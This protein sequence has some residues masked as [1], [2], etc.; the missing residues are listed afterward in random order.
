QI[1]YPGNPEVIDDYFFW[2]GPRR[3]APNAVTVVNTGDLP[4]IGF[5]VQ[6]LLHGPYDARWTKGIF[7]DGVASL[8]LDGASIVT[9]QDVVV[10]VLPARGL[11]TH[12]TFG[13]SRARFDG[14]L[15]LA[16]PHDTLYAIVGLTY[17]DHAVPGLAEV[18]KTFHRSP[19]LPLEPPVV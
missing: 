6:R 14:W 2:R 8:R 4:W 12:G 16:A 11:V 5:A 19:P 18:A 3:S 13:G 10:A 15:V 17:G 9:N 1:Q 7:D